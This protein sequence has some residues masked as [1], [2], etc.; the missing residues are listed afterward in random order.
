MTAVALGVVAYHD[1]SSL[2]RLLGS[3]AGFDDVIVVNV[4]DD[5]EVAAVAQRH[6]ARAIPLA[7]NPGY[8]AAVG[9]LVEACM[10]PFLLFCNDDVAFPAGAADR[11]RAAAR[12]GEVVAP[13][14]VDDDGVTVGSVRALPTPLRLLLEW[15]L[16]PDD[17]PTT[18]L[19]QKWRRPT[20]VEAVDAVTAAAVLVDRD[21]LRR[22]PLPTEFVLYWEELSWFWRLR[23]QRVR[24]V[25]DPSL[26]VIRRGGRSELGEPKWRL[27]GANLVRLGQ[28]RYGVVGRL[29]YGLVG[30]VWLLRLAVTDSV[31]RD[32]RER[33]RARRAGLSG[34][35]QGTVRST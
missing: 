29:L 27:L 32:R 4:E 14:L 25:M 31:R 13:R 3:A 2:D 6:G 24:V 28:E 19:V 15:V 23:D 33:W 7:G 10:H 34:L 18:D 21:L 30:V 9:V 8:A 12:L 22:V 17:G 20:Q 11:A 35:V 16:L 1:G 26:A 5:A